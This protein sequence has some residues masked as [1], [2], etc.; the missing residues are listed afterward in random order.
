[1]LMFCLLRLGC[2]QLFEQ[3]DTCK[4]I[5]KAY[6]HTVHLYS[7]SLSACNDLSKQIIRVPF[8]KTCRKLTSNFL[9]KNHVSR[10]PSYK[11]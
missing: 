4:R 9:K 7:T 10:Y 1:M 2:R 11:G 3:L 8:E 5:Y 6:S